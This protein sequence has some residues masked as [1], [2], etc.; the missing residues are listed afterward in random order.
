MNLQTNNE[1][2]GNAPSF[3]VLHLTL[4]GGY[5]RIAVV[6]GRSCLV[7]WEALVV[8]MQFTFLC[9]LAPKALRLQ[10][11]TDHRTCFPPSLRAY[12]YFP[13]RSEKVGA[14]RSLELMIQ[15]GA[16]KLH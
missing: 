7:R 4:R 8:R 2:A 15:T 1:Q 12:T 10:H 9:G 13:D 14:A 6:C 11:H 5:F 3:K 16:S